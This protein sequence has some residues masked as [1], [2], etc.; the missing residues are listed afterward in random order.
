MGCTTF[1]LAEAPPADPYSP[2]TE[3]K[4]LPQSVVL[5][6]YEVCPFCCK[7]KAFLDYHKIPYRCVE[8]NPLSKAELKWSD[9]KKVPVVVLEDG[10]GG[11]QQVNDSTAIMSW[12]QAEVDAQRAQQAQQQQAAG[13][14][15]RSWWRS[16]AAS[17]PVTSSGKV[18]APGPGAGGGDEQEARWRK[19]VDNHFVRVI[20]VNIYRSAGEAWQTFD[21]I[22]INGNFGWLERQAS[23]VAGAGVMWAI[24][25]RLQKKYGIQGDL[26][27]QLY[28]SA[29]EWAD[30]VGDHPFLGGL[31]P[32]LADLAVFGVTRSI[33]GTNTFRDLMLNSRIAPW[34]ERMARAVGDSARLP[35]QP[36]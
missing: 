14:G 2:P 16:L 24:S 6:Q 10:S 31:Q 9:Y 27:E 18:A 3:L 7:V 23:R 17:S 11:S 21:Y 22:T 26:R 19:W 4:G 12:L 35:D 32:N 30:A 5:Y 13:G 20:T 1:A 8:V 29:N 33:V 25:G 34:Y 15:S 28:T 36:K